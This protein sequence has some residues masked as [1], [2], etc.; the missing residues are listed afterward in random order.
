MAANYA[1]ASTEF[2]AVVSAY[3]TDPNSG[4]SL[5]YLG[6]LDYRSGKYTSAIKNYDRVLSQ[7]PNSPKAP[8][9][10]LHKGQALLETNKREA[11]ITELRA[12]IT[13]FPNTP[14]AAQARGR[15]SGMGV[16]VVPRR[17]AQ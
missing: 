16:P 13:H 2:A 15:L 11:G 3:P 1:L 9:S 12:L 17:A 4:N 7:F 14:E 8:V 10:H 6:E 5:Y